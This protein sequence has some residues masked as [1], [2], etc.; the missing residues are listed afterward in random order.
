MKA[1]KKMKRP[2][3]KWI[4]PLCIIVVIGIISF[5][6]Y[7][8]TQDENTQ[9]IERIVNNIFSDINESDYR[10]LSKA[11][12]DE[13]T[14]ATQLPNWIKERFQNDMTDQ[15]FS[16]LL[17]TAAYN[18]S[19][20]GYVNEKEMKLENLEINLNDNGYEFEG[21]LHISDKQ[22]ESKTVEITL[23]GSSQVNE[24]G[25]VSYIN[26][27]NMEEIVEAIKS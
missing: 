2:K 10:E 23:K 5:V 22:K 7:R 25:L 4:L 13:Y 26:I 16:T 14:D 21:Q 20:L 15:G 9:R 19:V 3:L 27:V 11:E 17:E 8:I 24:E 18:I 6:I 1:V 12:T